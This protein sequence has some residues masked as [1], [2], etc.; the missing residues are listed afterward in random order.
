MFLIRATPTSRLRNLL[1]AAITKQSLLTPVPQKSRTTKWTRSELFEKQNPDAHAF[2]LSQLSQPQY[3]SDYYSDTHTE[4]NH[5]YK[6]LESLLDSFYPERTIAITSREPIYMTPALKA[7]LRRK[8]RLMRAGRTDKAS[9]L[10]SRIGRIIQQCSPATNR[11]GG[12]Q[13]HVEKSSRDNRSPEPHF[14]STARCHSWCAQLTLR[15]RLHRQVITQSRASSRA[16]H[17]VSPS[18]ISRFS[19]CSI[20]YI[21][22][23]QVSIA[24]RHGFSG[25]VLAVF[26]PTR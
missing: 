5:L 17:A 25:L 7:L 24:S 19:A 21:T 11:Q 14:W 1:W 15:Q 8:N 18:A 2:F 20:D 23:R 13:T 9:A 3:Q 22:L 6:Y 16:T 12:R 4:F 10:A 26:W